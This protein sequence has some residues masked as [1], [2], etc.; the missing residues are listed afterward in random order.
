MTSVQPDR[1]GTL[2]Q[3]ADGW[4]LRFTR[5]LGKPPVVAWQAFADP[6]LVAQWFPSSI[7][8]RLVTGAKLTFTIAAYDVEPF[9]GEVIEADEPR[10]LVVR[11]GPDVLRFELTEAGDGTELTMTIELSELGRAARDTA[12]WHECLDKL[13]AALAAD[14]RPTDAARWADVHPLYVERFGPDGSAIGP[15][16]EYLDAHQE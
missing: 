3:T 8:G 10:L 14:D 11:W 2:T 6:Q 7:E 15:P 16:Q 12:G 13:E 5:H 4:R 1:L 9:F